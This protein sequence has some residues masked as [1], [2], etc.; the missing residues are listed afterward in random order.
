MIN[1]DKLFKGK[2]LKQLIKQ[3]WK[4]IGL[5]ISIIIIII[6]YII[7]IHNHIEKV[8]YTNNVI[9]IAKKNED[10]VFS[11]EKIY[12]C[13]SAN[14][15]GKTSTQNTGDFD[16]YQ[17]TDMAIYINNNQEQ[18]GISNENTVKELYIDNIELQVNNNTGN[19]SLKYTNLKKIGSREVVRDFS[20]TDRID[21]N[22]VYTNKENEMANY[23]SPTFY[24]DCSNPITLKYVNDLDTNYSVDEGNSVKFD[25]S[26]LKDAGIKI[27]DINARVKFKINLINNNNEYYSCWINL[28]MPLNEIYNGTSIKS[29]T[30]NGPIYDLFKS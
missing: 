10:T 12:V 13:S 15:I 22:V 28:E 17:Y 21:F 8:K 30:T 5:I 3:N 4:E 24:T 9:D 6:S 27:E 16:I 1:W 29:K 23:D 2:N 14:A 11:V 20:N 25:G 26:I 7:I 18:F 19:Q